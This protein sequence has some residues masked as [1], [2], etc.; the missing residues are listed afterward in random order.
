VTLET[1]E[2][3]ESGCDDE[4]GDVVGHGT[5]HLSDAGTELTVEDGALGPELDAASVP[6]RRAASDL[7][8]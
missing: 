7:F 5:A 8:R 2:R 6:T 3:S 1:I 4:V